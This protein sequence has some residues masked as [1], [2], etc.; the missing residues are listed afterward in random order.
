M[1]LAKLQ[2]LVITQ[3]TIAALETAI[4]KLASG[5]AMLAADTGTARTLPANWSQTRDFIKVEFFQVAGGPFNALVFYVD[6]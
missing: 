6:G 5:A 4:N 3:A 1:K 2:C